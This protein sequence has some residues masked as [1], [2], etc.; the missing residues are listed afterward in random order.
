MEM[1]NKFKIEHNKQKDKDSYPLG[2]FDYQQLLTKYLS[3]VVLSYELVK[4]NEEL[5][6]IN[7][8]LKRQCFRDGQTGLYNY[9]HF[10]QQLQ[11]EFKRAG[12][13]KESLTCIMLDVD[14]F[15]SIND[16]YGHR[17]GDFVLKKLE[18]ILRRP[19]RETDIVA[20]YGGDEF[21]ILVPNTGYQG[22]YTIAQKV[23]ARIRNYTFQNYGISLKISVSLGLA[24]T[25]DDQV[26]S[27]GQLVDFA[28]KA[29]YQVK[30]RGGGGIL[31]FRKLD[32]AQKRLT[33][34]KNRSTNPP[35]LSSDYIRETDLVYSR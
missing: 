29:L 26:Q 5:K 34:K 18:C 19:M 4:T 3:Y 22:A 13:Y 25:P 24:S 14:N 20:R 35:E 30:R 6:T 16:T 32:K 17:F 11:V 33:V 8:K 10:R 7:K 9:R 31:G 21:S 12:R 1:I 2:V 23:Q 27:P 28:D 15:K